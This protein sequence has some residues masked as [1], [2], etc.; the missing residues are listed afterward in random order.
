[1]QSCPTE[2]D[3]RMAHEAFI[4]HT[5]DRYY[6]P[7]TLDEAVDILA[8]ER[9][10][11]RVIAGGT[12]LIIELERGVR[13]LQAVVDITYIP[14]LNQITLTDARIHL[15]PLVTHNHVVAS[16]LCVEHALPLAQAAWEV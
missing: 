14:G 6:A 5:W 4:P 10:Q 8:R 7:R 2:D 16:R 15:G 13:R 1:M 12:D 11:A 3:I 9:G